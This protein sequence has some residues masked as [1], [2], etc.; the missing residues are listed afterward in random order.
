MTWLCSP[1]VAVE[2]MRWHAVP[3]ECRAVLGLVGVQ[4]GVYR[5]VEGIP[6][7]F[8]VEFLS[9][10]ALEGKTLGNLVGNSVLVTFFSLLSFTLAVR[11]R[12]ITWFVQVNLA[13][14]TRKMGGGQLWVIDDYF[15]DDVSAD[16]QEWKVKG[17]GDVP[18]RICEN[19][20]NSTE[21]ALENTPRLVQVQS[22]W[23]KLDLSRFI[24]G[25]LR[26]YSPCLLLFPQASL[27]GC[28][29]FPFPVLG[30]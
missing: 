30:N 19:W 21:K 4:S 10:R 28:W 16:P 13:G 12:R 24:L 5:R 9:K 25:H 6:S 17:Q 14:I 7:C 23:V 11:W 8:G 22:I 2:R 3:M 29:N 27:L 1:A 20:L 18:Y 15:H 26:Q